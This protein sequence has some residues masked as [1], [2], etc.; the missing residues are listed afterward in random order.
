M[1]PK[2]VLPAL[3]AIALSLCGSPSRAEKLSRR[4]AI[5]QALAQ[6]PQIAAA[7]ARRAQ[8][9]AEQIQ[10]DSARFPQLS[11]ELGVGPSL[12]ATLVPGTAVESTRGR[13]E[14]A[15]KDL[16]VVM[17]GRLSVIQPLYTFG[18]IDGFRAAAAHGVRAREAQ[19]QMTQAD[20]ALEVARLYEASLFARDSQ[21]FFE[22]LEN[23]VVRTILATQERLQAD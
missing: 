12:R 5:A 15:A 16:S 6:N 18:K 8:S 20:I 1:K 22:E 9:D 19:T 2:V 23:Y 14:L 10:A 21:R 3:I 13:Y 4:A 11:V 7:R 17:G